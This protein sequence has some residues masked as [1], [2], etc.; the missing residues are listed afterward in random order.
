MCSSDLTLLD[1][2]E[3]ARRMGEEGTAWVTGRFS[4]RRLAEDM[5]SLYGELLARNAP[6][7]ERAP[8]RPR[9]RRAPSETASAIR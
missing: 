7:R 5:A 6:R 1:D 8:N 3:G 9:S 4:A 2:P